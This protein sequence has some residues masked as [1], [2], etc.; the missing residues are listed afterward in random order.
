MRSRRSQAEQATSDERA[1]LQREVAELVRV[2]EQSAVQEAA[3][4][5]RAEAAERRSAALRDACEAE[6]RRL[7]ASLDERERQRCEAE[8]RAEAAE[9]RVQAAEARAAE[10]EA[11]M[12]QAAAEHAAYVARRS[13]EGGSEEVRLGDIVD[14]A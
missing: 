10:A 7:A 11:N 9:A 8:A 2:V 1:K 3:A 6:G 12:V 5:S 13:L 14:F 4:T